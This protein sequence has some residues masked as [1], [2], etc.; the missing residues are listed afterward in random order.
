MMVTNPCLCIIINNCNAMGCYLTKQPIAVGTANR[1]SRANAA[2]N[3]TT[4]D[5]TVD[6]VFS[7]G[8]SP[9]SIIVKSPPALELDGARIANSDAIAAHY[10]FG[11]AGVRCKNWWQL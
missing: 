7:K 5:T 11:S 2:T 3:K 6:K 4:T 1:C 9:D 8:P 10:G